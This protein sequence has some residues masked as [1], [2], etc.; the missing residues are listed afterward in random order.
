MCGF[1]FGSPHLPHF[2]GDEADISPTIPITNY[3]AVGIC[4]CHYL[5]FFFFC[6][7]YVPEVKIFIYLFIYILVKKDPPEI[8]QMLLEH[9]A[10]RA[11]LPT[12]WIRPDADEDL[13]MEKLGFD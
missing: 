5:F 8:L 10:I 11:Q 7:L 3:R 2:Q 1:D 6:F 13:Q 4:F 12:V 9:L